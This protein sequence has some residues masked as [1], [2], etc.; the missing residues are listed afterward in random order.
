MENPPGNFRVSATWS[1]R[2]R[3]GSQQ[4]KIIRR[5]LSC[6]RDSSNSRPTVEESVHSESNARLR[7]L[8]TF[9]LFRSLLM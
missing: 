9:S 7:S 3:R 2:R 8:A 5:R 6:T 4:V 1:C